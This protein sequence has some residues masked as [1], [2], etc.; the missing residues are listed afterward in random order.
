MKKLSFILPLFALVIAIAASAFTAPR[1][2]SG[3]I[4]FPVNAAGQA[5]GLGVESDTD[6]SGCNGTGDLCSAALDITQTV[7]NGNGYSPAEGVD[8]S[9]DFTEQRMH[10]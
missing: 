6:P 10:N 7:P 8:I 3:T 1:A 2:G 4:W 5:T 9:T